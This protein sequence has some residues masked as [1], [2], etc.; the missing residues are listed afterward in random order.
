MVIFGEKGNDYRREVV[1]GSFLLLYEVNEGC[2]Q[3]RG[4]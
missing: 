3:R 1:E 2:I 4:E